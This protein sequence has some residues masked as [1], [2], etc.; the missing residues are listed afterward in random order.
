MLQ[1][2]VRAKRSRRQP[3]A[4]EVG[5]GERG[6]HGVGL[7]RAGAE[8][9]VRTHQA[10]EPISGRSQAVVR[11]VVLH[12]AEV[13]AGPQGQIPAHP[14]VDGVRLGDE[15]PVLENAGGRHEGRCEERSAR[16][17]DVDSP[18]SDAH[19]RN[20]QNA[21]GCSTP[22]PATAD[23]QNLIRRQPVH[24]LN[25]PGAKITCRIDE[26]ARPAEE[27][28]EHIPRVGVAS[29]ERHP[30]AEAVV[31]SDEGCIL[32]VLARLHHA[33]DHDSRL[34]VGRVAVEQRG[35]ETGG[36]SGRAIGGGEGPKLPGA[37]ARAGNESR[38]EEG[39]AEDAP[40]VAGYEPDQRRIRQRQVADQILVLTEAFVAREEEV[41]VAHE[42]AAHGAAEEVIAQ[43]G[44]NRVAAVVKVRTGVEEIACA[45]PVVPEILVH[46]SAE[47]VGAGLRDDVDLPTRA[48]AE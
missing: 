36:D 33:G 45:H 37:I 8:Q 5:G 21:H 3:V 14:R 4:A 17:E 16:H 18:L 29:R 35:R 34:T 31:G 22:E 11:E 46:G 2:A 39:P 40:Q 44:W 41:T 19:V 13:E 12:G 9:G 27:P 10:C 15:L 47:R 25:H 6:G 32:H 20:V 43:R 28:L 7:L 38:I 26:R 1:R 24:E 30:V 48:P 23:F 42:G